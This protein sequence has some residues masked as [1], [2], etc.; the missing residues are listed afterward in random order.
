[1][2]GKKFAI[3]NFV[4]RVAI[5]DHTSYNFMLRNGDPAR[6]LTVYFNDKTIARGYHAYIKARR[7]LSVKN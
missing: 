7:L 1:M 2:T 6:E 4:T 3:I 5:S